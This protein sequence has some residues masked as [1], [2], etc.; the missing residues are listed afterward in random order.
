MNQERWAKIEEI[1][2]A[3]LS[4]PAGERLA[5]LPGVCGDDVALREEVESLLAQDD[6]AAGPIDRPAWEGS[7]GLLQKI[8]DK[9]MPAGTRL[10][11]YEITGLLGQGGM[12]RVYAARDSRLGRVVA[13]KISSAEFGDRF[14]QEARAV[15]ALNHPNICTLHDV[16][17]NYLVMELVEG[18]T[19]GERIKQG[20]IP[21][22]ECLDIGRQI[23]D[24]LEAAHERGV[25]HRDLKPGN[26]KIKPDGTVKVIDFGLAK[27]TEAAGVSS[28][29]APTLTA[30]RPGMIMGT[31]A[32][33][34]PEQA[35]GKP[36]DRRVDIWG[37]GVVLAEMLTGTR[38]FRGETASET[39][40]AVIKDRPDLRNLPSDL[41]S[42]VRK[43]LDRCLEKD[44]RKRLRDI[45]EARI[46][47]EGGA[48]VDDPVPR[49]VVQ[50]PMWLTAAAVALAG[51]L[52]AIAWRGSGALT[53][54]PVV[55]MNL[56]VPQ[57][58][59]RGFSVSPDGRLLAY[60]ATFE[61]KLMI[62]TLD[63]HVNHA[64]PRPGTEGGRFPFWSPDSK[65]IGFSAD[66]KLKRVEAAGVS[67]P[68]VLCEGAPQR[69]AWGAAGVIIFTSGVDGDGPLHRVSE[70]G[71]N[72]QRLD[73]PALHEVGHKWPAFLSDG[74]RYIYFAE[75]RNGKSGEVYSSSLDKP[76]ERVRV[77]TTRVSALLTHPTAGKPGYLL[78]SANSHLAAQVFDEDTLRLK[79]QPIMV[80]DHVA[81]ASALEMQAAASDNGVVFYSST[82]AAT[83]RFAWVN[84]EGRV[85]SMEGP[86]DVYNGDLGLSPD[87]RKLA[88]NRDLERF[89]IWTYE[90]GR[91][92]LT[93]IT[94]TPTTGASWSPDGAWIVYRSS[95]EGWGNLFRKR[96]DGSGAEERLTNV[97][98]EQMPSSFS[99]DGTQLLFSQ[100]SAEAKRDIWLMRVQGDRPP[101]VFLRT[102][103]D[104]F[105]AKFS[106]DGKWVA[107]TASEGG[108]NEIFVQGFSSSTGAVPGA[109]W[110]VSTGGGSY[111][112]WR[113]DGKELFFWSGSHLMAAFVKAGAA[114]L[115]LGTARAL[116][117]HPAPGRYDVAPDGQQI[118]VK[119]RTQSEASLTVV[120]N[121][122]GL[123]PH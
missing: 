33:M 86:P 10:G 42:P 61:G 23:A 119:I 51:V 48:A 43:L 63:L 37:F 120:T 112:R 90:F 39:L 123:L 38:L 29:A 114:G 20:P 44:P 22:A 4:L 95:P 74:K 25:V 50:W 75:G 81:H 92:T 28:D 60:S 115:E 103:F 27:A 16:G 88:T 52:G 91:G 64:Q 59:L 3:A 34:A 76:N 94:F 109:R 70:L 32:Y 118:L 78:Y 117:P 9:D 36:V 21:V 18:L 102:P 108:P 83:S 93:P 5:Y 111:P 2:N 47:L 71:G 6:S 15:A 1:Y 82:P 122:H 31:A 56:T 53:P 97:P 110:K 40:A 24:A 30:T 66:G 58:A 79:G 49:R 72:P 77:V 87:T 99:P 7:E 46:V 57:D 17:P 11:P 69:G 65:S 67:A 26:V 68:Q 106:P 80:A 98:A 19:L 62:W 96:S 35:A 45:G 13:L 84:R 14:R 107:Y 85:I 104:E 121:W 89:S 116:F 73:T 12:G 105:D 113:G 41:P 54:L 100:V 8:A 101:T 55:R